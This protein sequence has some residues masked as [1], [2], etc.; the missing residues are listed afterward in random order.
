M[1][2]TYRAPDLP[3]GKIT[4]YLVRDELL[5]CF[6]SANREFMRILNQP[7]EDEALKAQV[8]QFV[9][10]VFESCGVNF[11]D[12]TKDG[13]I[14]AIDQCKSN[15]ESMMG[16]KGADIIAHHYTEMMKLVEK[17]PDSAVK[18]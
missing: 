6:E 3:T 13:I 1:T 15:A 5:K 9:T 17:L 4:P 7:T 10:Q 14:K 8:R 12:P 11:E 2:E 16:P 18:S